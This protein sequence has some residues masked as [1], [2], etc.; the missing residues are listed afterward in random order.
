MLKKRLNNSGAYKWLIIA[1]STLSLLLLLCWLLLHHLYPFLA[2]NK[3]VDNADILIVEGWIDNKNLLLAKKE[4]EQNAYEQMVVAST[5]SPI[6]FIELEAG[7]L[8]FD[9]TVSPY[10]TLIGVNKITLL[11]FAVSE[12]E[13]YPGFSLLVNDSVL[14]DEVQ[15]DAQLNAYTYDISSFHDPIRN[16]SLAYKQDSSQLQ[17]PD[18]LFVHSLLIDELTVP[19]WAHNVK[20]FK[21]QRK[22]IKNQ[23]QS[24]HFS[25]AEVAKEIMLYYGIPPDKIVAIST[26]KEELNRTFSSAETVAHWV[27]RHYETVPAMNIFTEGVHARRS[28]ML[29]QL[30][31]SGQGKSGV[32]TLGIIAA[33]KYR[34]NRKN[35]WKKEEGREYVFVQTLKYIY[36]KFLF[37]PYEE[38]SS[39]YMATDAI[40]SIAEDLNELCR[41]P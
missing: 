39:N 21:E 13:V 41:A 36:A 10:N 7:V 29:Y 23:V 20:Y 5:S 35:W 34:Y 32:E 9:F 18:S 6:V 19:G 12:D 24:K 38:V 28:L 30:A 26:P 31:F 16:I 3:S 11:A 25:D 22:S 15:T 4:F 8:K 40:V 27:S 14:I 2:L 17:Q 37:S 1:G 33:P